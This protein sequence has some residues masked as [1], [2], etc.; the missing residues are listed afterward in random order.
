MR[1]DILFFIWLFMLTG[2]WNAQVEI[3]NEYI[4]NGNWTKKNEQAWANSITID[5]MKVKKD[6]TIDPFS[7]LSQVQIISKL[8]EDSSFMHYAN[9]K[10][11][12]E[13]RYKNKKIYFN[14]YNG[15]SWGSESRHSGFKTN[16]IGVLQAGNWYRFS[17][18]GWAG[19]IYIYIDSAN[20][21]HRF[22][23]NTGAY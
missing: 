19:E 17:D 23:V 14:K 18:L 3:T 16:T 10:I 20:K 9:I 13:E 4:I 2:C 21:T 6:S 11:K 15:F 7:D 12:P 5:K 1:I 22:N 8:E